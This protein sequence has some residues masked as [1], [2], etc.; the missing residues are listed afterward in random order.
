TSHAM[1]AHAVR[2][3]RVRVTG[4]RELRTEQARPEPLAQREPRR[5]R[6]LGTVVGMLTGDALAPR[7]ETVSVAHAREQDAP[8]LDDARRDTERLAQRQPDLAQLDAVHPHGR[9]QRESSASTAARTCD[10]SPG[11]VHASSTPPAYGA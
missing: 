4:M 3:H 5:V 10:G 1:T 6:R 2:Q 9:T 7:L 8:V 11:C